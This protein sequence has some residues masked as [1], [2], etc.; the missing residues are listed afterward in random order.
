MP[1]AYF[2][3]VTDAHV[4]SI[5]HYVRSVLVRDER[6]G[7]EH[8]DAL[9]RAWGT[10]PATLPIPAK[11]PKHFKRSGLRRAILD[12]L[13]NGPLTGA[14]LAGKVGDG[15]EPKVAYKRTYAALYKMKAVGLVIHEGRLWLAITP[16]AASSPSKPG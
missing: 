6:E 12:T 16:P 10:D 8:V 14:E 7:V 9:L 1:R 5:L 2:R 11:W 3:P 4:D 15:L 13:R